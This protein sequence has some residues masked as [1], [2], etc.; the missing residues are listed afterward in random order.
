MTKEEFL[1]YAKVLS[2]N[3]G[4][5]YIQKISSD[6]KPYDPELADLLLD[7]GKLWTRL[8]DHVNSKIEK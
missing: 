6:V 5:A 1:S 8:A 4:K 7:V 2:R 3:D